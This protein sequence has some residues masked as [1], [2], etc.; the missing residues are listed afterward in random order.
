MHPA[1]G[2]RMPEQ[3]IATRDPV[4]GKPVDPARALARTEYADVEYIFCS[5]TCMDRFTEDADIYTNLA[6]LGQ[7]QDR[8]R[9]S[10][11]DEHKGELTSAQKMGMDRS[12]APPAADPGG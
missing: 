1:T 8:D 6:G 7:L 10:R 4:C 9:A 5:Q 11:H 2:W 12:P 3:E